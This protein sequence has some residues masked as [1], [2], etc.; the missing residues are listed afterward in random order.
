MLLFA[1][2]SSFVYLLFYEAVYH[3]FNLTVYL[4]VHNS[5]NLSNLSAFSHFHQRNFS[6]LQYSCVFSRYTVSFSSL[7]ILSP[8][9]SL[10]P[11]LFSCLLFSPPPFPSLFLYFSLL[12][13]SSSSHLLFTSPPTQRHI[14]QDRMLKLRFA[15][16]S[17]WHRNSDR[18]SLMNTLVLI[19]H[20]SLP[21][22]AAGRKGKRASHY[23]LF[24]LVWSLILYYYNY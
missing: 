12:S 8:S 6:L 10:F 5:F 19:T 21:S 23:V 18:Y 3:C 17:P 7:V 22:R 2:F 13:S 4:S 16:L 24:P 15:L 9:L 14:K 1:F 11:L 20:F